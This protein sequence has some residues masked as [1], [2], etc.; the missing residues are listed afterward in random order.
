MTAPLLQEKELD[1]TQALRDSLC[2]LSKRM[3]PLVQV[4]TRE[5]VQNVVPTVEQESRYSAVRKTYSSTKQPGM[6][7]QEAI[8]HAPRVAQQRGS[9][10]C[11]PRTS[12]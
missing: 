4:T 6:L 11:D 1:G 12:A 10:L 2:A 8:A 5:V 3:Q 7:L 9:A